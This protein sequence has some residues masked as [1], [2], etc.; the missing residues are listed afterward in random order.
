MVVLAFVVIFKTEFKPAKTTKIIF[1]I[2]TILL[3]YKLLVWV[4]DGIYQDMHLGV[5]FMKL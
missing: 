2:L 3:L 4:I 1:A 5:I